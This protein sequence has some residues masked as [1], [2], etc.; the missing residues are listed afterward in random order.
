MTGLP[1]SPGLVRAHSSKRLLA[2]N[3]RRGKRVEDAG[4]FIAVLFA[5]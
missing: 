2:F 1:E 5:I 4:Q 3:G